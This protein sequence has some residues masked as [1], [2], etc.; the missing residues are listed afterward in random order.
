MPAPSVTRAGTSVFKLICERTIALFTKYWTLGKEPIYRMLDA[1][2][3]STS[4]YK[5]N[6]ITTGCYLSNRG[7]SCCVTHRKTM[8]CRCRRCASLKPVLMDKKFRMFNFVQASKLRAMYEQQQYISN[9]K[10]RTSQ[11]FNFL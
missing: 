7:P 3:K 10:L 9:G 2:P 6:T 8:A 4:S 1:A 11:S 5:A